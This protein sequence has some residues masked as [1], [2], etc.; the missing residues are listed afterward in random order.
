M[1]SS[2]ELR[3]EVAR[4]LDGLPAGAGAREAFA[5]LGEARLFAVHYP[6]EYGGRGGSLEDYA[7]V[8]EALGE[9]QFADE[10]HLVTVQGVGC[11]IWRFGTEA[12]RRKWLPEIASGRVLASLMLSEISAGSD[13]SAITTRAIRT[14]GGWSLSGEKCWSLHA[15]WS[16]IAICS[17]RTSKGANRYSGM[18]LFLVDLGRKGITVSAK[19][20]L[21]GES[22]FTTTFEGVELGEGDVLGRVDGGFSIVTAAAG[23]ERAGLD[24]LSRGGVWLR[25]AEDTLASLPELDGERRRA[26]LARLDY[27]LRGA[28]ALAYSTLATAA[29]LDF[30]YVR[31]AYSKYTCGEAAQAVARW[32][33]DDLLPEPAVASRPDLVRRLRAAVAEGPE[34]SISG[35]ALD[36]LLDTISLDPAVG[37]L[38]V[39]PSGDARGGPCLEWVETSMQRAAEGRPVDDL[40]PPASE[41]ADRDLLG[42]AATAVGVGRRAVVL[43]RERAGSRFIG[44][45]PLIEMQSTGHR[46]ARAAARIAVARGS[47]QA[48]AREHDAGSGAHHR[49]LATAAAAAEAAFACARALMQ[50]YGAAGTS[51]AKPVGAFEA[52][53]SAGAALGPPAEL[54][55]QAGRRSGLGTT[56]RRKRP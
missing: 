35:N 19:P 53:Q 14:E 27:E 28:R 52:C 47:V 21:M 56:P 10:V 51:E 55:L 24:Y 46:I 6:R 22:Y 16:R 26:D 38:D 11:T 29:G 15:D 31:S 20:R 39:V 40:G 30:D 8:A 33:S 12:Q 1:S 36:I 7:V 18:T 42:R 44:G 2:G 3:A 41:A 23:F 25:A 4:I 43:A 49:V 37:E 45:R 50:V 5:A 13:A 34:L 48:A 17:A 32:I 9:R 54:W